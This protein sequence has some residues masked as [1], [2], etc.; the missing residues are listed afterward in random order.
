MLAA[1]PDAGEQAAMG[2]QEAAEGHA[3]DETPGPSS[4]AGGSYLTHMVERAGIEPAT[5]SLQS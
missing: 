2:P 3:N 4:E 5:P 1:D